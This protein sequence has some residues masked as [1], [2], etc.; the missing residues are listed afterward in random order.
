MPTREH[1]VSRRYRL[2][3]LQTVAGSGAAVCVLSEAAARLYRRYL[4]RDPEILP[5]GVLA[6]EFAVDE[7]RAD[8]PTLISAASIGD[9]RKRGALMLDAFGRLRE[10]HPELRLEVARTADPHLSP[11][12]FELPDGARWIEPDSTEALARAYSRASASVLAARDEAFGLVLVESLAAGTPVAAARSGSCPEIVDSP[13]VGSLFDGDD[14]EALAAAMDEALE[15]GG[16]AE[17]AAACR[18]RAAEYDWGRVVER[19]EAVY[20]RVLSA[21]AAAPR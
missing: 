8:P 14:P 2:E 17:T 16:R 6:D 15:A 5:G 9:P 7:P 21:P 20:E 11:Y 13:E 4:L 3:M 19:Y 12:S 10:R 1:L 18:T